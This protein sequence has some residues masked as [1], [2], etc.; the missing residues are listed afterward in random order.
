MTV[1]SS[2]TGTIKPGRFED[3]LSQG[4]EVAKLYERLG[5]SEVRLLNAAV[6]GEASNT[7][8]F[9][10]EYENAES[11]GAFTDELLADPEMQSLLMRIRSADS[12]VD[13][14]Q[15]ST[16]TE[17]P[18]DRKKKAGRGNIVE[19]YVSRVTPGRLEEA[20]ESAKRAL[21]FVERHGA[22]NGGLFQ[23]G[24]AGSGTGLMLASWEFANMRAAGKAA[25]AW[26]TDPKGQA[27]AAQMYDADSPTTMVFGGMYQ[28]VPL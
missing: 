25:D 10:A 23:L 3:F 6:A 21:T 27:I 15:L 8:V 17:I 9:S 1:I 5:A 19:V 4:L 26:S 2:V 12:P 13:I 18:L 7:W 24:A 11:Y 16:S 20:L 22:R 14:Q 28:V